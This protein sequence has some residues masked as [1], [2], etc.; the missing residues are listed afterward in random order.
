MSRPNSIGRHNTFQAFTKKSNPTIRFQQENRRA[1][2]RTPI[3]HVVVII[4]E[5]RTFDNYFGSYPHAA[6]VP[7]EQSWGGVPAP[8][9]VARPGP[10]AVNG[11]TPALLQ[12]NPSRSLIGGPANPARL[13]PAAAYTRAMHNGYTSEHKA[14]PSGLMEHYAQK[15]AR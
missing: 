14:E 13:R 15:T 2:T 12:N 3:K 9:F 7:G 8:K 11:L 4:P 6:N 10:P 5:N 1:S